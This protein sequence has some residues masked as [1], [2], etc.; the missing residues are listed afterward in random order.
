[1]DMNAAL[2]LVADQLNLDGQQII[3]Y[4]DEDTIPGSCEYEGMPGRDPNAI[5]Y[6]N[7]GK[8]LYALVRAL[9]PAG[10]LESGTNHG[11]SAHHMIAAQVKNVFGMLVTVDNNPEADLAAVPEEWRSRVILRHADIRVEA[12]H[13]THFDFIHEDAS[14]EPD[15]VYAIYSNLDHLLPHGGVVVSHDT[16]LH[17]WPQIEAGIKAAQEK[18]HFDDPQRYQFDGSPCGFSVLRYGLPEIKDYRYS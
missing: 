5:P 11:G 6:T 2:M 1:M 4:A 10:I 12:N 15:T 16:A 7:D 3:S 9:R 18:L 14:H 8:F 17:I 13:M